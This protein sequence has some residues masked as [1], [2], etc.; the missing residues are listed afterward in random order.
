MSYYLPFENRK[1]YKASKFTYEYSDKYG[2]NTVG[3]H[4]FVLGTSVRWSIAKKFYVEG[5]AY[6][7]PDKQS[8]LPWDPDF[9]YGFGY[10]NWEA[11]R[12]NISYGNWIANRFPWNDKTMQHGFNNGELKVMFTWAL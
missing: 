4:K 1:P 3:N 9:T 11:F 6:Y 7:Y 10:F 5:A 8:V 12:L 2:V